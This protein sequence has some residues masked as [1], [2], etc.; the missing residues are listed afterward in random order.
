M[1]S[2]DWWLLVLSFQ[3]FGGFRDIPTTWWPLHSSSST[4][5]LPHCPDGPRTATLSGFSVGMVLRFLFEKALGS[6]VRDECHFVS[7]VS[8]CG[9]P[10]GSRKSKVNML[11]CAE[12]VWGSCCFSKNCLLHAISSRLHGR[13]VGSP[14]SE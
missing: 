12:H 6:S 4:T 2:Y 7:R 14:I 3:V 13:S 8:G 11:N 5:Q 1:P 9:H 10:K